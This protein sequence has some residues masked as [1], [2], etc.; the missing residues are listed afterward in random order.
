MKLI[1]RAIID[2]VNA[3]L[4]IFVIAWSILNLPKAPLTR[5]TRM[6]TLCI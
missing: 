6:L 3:Y 5:D 4:I 2:G 1:I